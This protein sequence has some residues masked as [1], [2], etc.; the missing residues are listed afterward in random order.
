MMTFG[1][2]RS[3]GFCTSLATIFGAVVSLSGAVFVSLSS[4]RSVS[5]L[6][7][8]LPP[9]AR[10]KRKPNESRTEGFEIAQM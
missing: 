3:N 1:H 8:T 5:G 7:G 2:R 4:Y 6:L 10:C 9:G